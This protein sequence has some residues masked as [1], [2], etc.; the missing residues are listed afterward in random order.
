M[1]ANITNNNGKRLL[2]AVTAML[3]IVCAVAAVAAPTDAADSTKPTADF[4]GVEAINV[5]SVD[6]LADIE[7]YVSET[8]V[9]TIST[10]TVLNITGTLGS[11]DEPAISQIVLKDDLQIQGTGTIYIKNTAKAN[12]DATVMFEADAVLSITGGVKVNLDA[13]NGEGFTSAHVI[14]N[15]KNSAVL[16]VT[17]GAVLTIT[18]ETGTSSWYN[19]DETTGK[20]TYMD[21]NNAT[22]N[23]NES[24]SVQGVVLD[25]DNA[26]ITITNAD[27]TAIVLKNGSTVTGSDIT[28]N[29]AVNAGIYLK[30]TVTVEQNST[31]DITSTGS[32]IN[33]E[34]IEGATSEIKIDATSAVSAGSVGFADETSSQLTISGDGSF[35]GNLTKGSSTQK[36][37][38]YTLKGGITFGDEENIPTITGVTLKT[39]ADAAGNT[40]TMYLDADAAKNVTYTDGDIVNIGEFKYTVF[41][42]TTSIDLKTVNFTVG[43]SLGTPTYTGQSFSLRDLSPLSVIF[44]ATYED[45][46]PATL[47][48]SIDPS[49]TEA[50]EDLES[51]IN[52]GQYSLSV[53]VMISNGGTGQYFSVDANFEIVP[54]DYNVTLDCGDGWNEGAYTDADAPV[55][56]ITDVNNEPVDIVPTIVFINNDATRF[57]DPSKLVAGIYDVEVSFNSNDGNY[58]DYKHTFT[59][60]LTVG[61]FAPLE[62]TIG[63][64]S[65]EKSDIAEDL[66]GFAP[67]V[68]QSGI[69]FTVDGKKV[70]VTGEVIKVDADDTETINY[71][72][73]L[74]FT[75]PQAGYYLA[76]YVTVPEGQYVDIDE[77]TIT[78]YKADGTT[79]MESGTDYVKIASPENDTNQ[80]Y[81]NYIGADLPANTVA[82]E[83][84]VSDDLFKVTV[85]LDGNGGY[86]DPSTYDVTLTDLNLYRIVLKDQYNTELVYY[87][88]EGYQFYLPSGAG[89]GFSCWTTEENSPFPS[90]Q[91]NSVFVISGDYANGDYEIVLTASYSGTVMPT[92]TPT[93]PSE[94]I[95]I[96]VVKT[97]TG[98]DVYLI[99][100]DGGYVPV[101]SVSLAVKVSYVNA[102]GSSMLI[103]LPVEPKTVENAENSS[104]V[105]VSFD[106]QTPAGDYFDAIYSVGASFAGDDSM[107]ILY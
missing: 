47:A 101:D 82:D 79:E 10:P 28:V 77:M 23:F 34:N 103:D 43:V 32:G 76:Y 70:N 89:Q 104:I 86:Y 97:E 54:A 50:N 51:M 49:Q 81:V 106:L 25:A 20:E 22:V 64:V 21:V 102:A 56:T 3:M 38:T 14:N 30:G 69:E 90:F 61:A 107:T 83:G 59:D 105:V 1:I 13:A 24:H 99:G 94:N 72:K 29:G 53:T 40:P 100:L 87:Y 41:N 11:A 98:V 57:T 4:A 15:S 31:I 18:Q 46:S 19:S 45:S 16:S 78:L 85:D 6:D 26:T 75:S 93:E 27:A 62:S 74:G 7:G 84:E 35:T 95:L 66:L 88:P 73:T 9:L 12:N 80:Y 42:R 68:I 39:E 8:R 36:A 67:S 44:S 71:L 65:M 63:F 58:N 33:V 52:V 96:S 92:P 37:V 5:A 55:V 60:V 17:N 91:T 2:A 48:S